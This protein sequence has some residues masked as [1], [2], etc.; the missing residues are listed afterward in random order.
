MALLLG[1]A[2]G[3]RTSPVTA[4]EEATL[5]AEAERFASNADQL[6]RIGIRY[7]EGG[8]YTRAADVLTAALGVQPSFAAAVYLGLAQEGMQRYEEAETA[9]RAARTFRVSAG[10]REELDR[11]LAAL[12]LVRLTAEARAAIARE[13]ELS[14]LPALPRSVAVL[15]WRFV[16]ENRRLA[17]LGAGV[18][19]LVMTDLGRISSLTLVE[20][21]RV[22]AL[23]DE[24]SLATSGLVDSA[25][26]V[27]SGRLLRAEWVVA[28]LVRQTTNGVRLEAKIYR[29]SDAA[30]QAGGSQQDRVERLFDMQKA[31]TLA[32]VEQLGVPVT[33][34][35]RRAVSE[36]PTADLQAFLAFSE[37]VAAQG[38]GDYRAAG[39]LF[40]LAAGRD[41]AFGMARSLGVL[42]QMLI[43]AE[44]SNRATLARLASPSAGN[45]AELRAAALVGAVQAVAPTTGGELD[46]RTRA[47]GWQSHLPETLGQDNPTK[48]AIIGEIV[49][50]IPRP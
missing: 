16:G 38:R 20:R 27:R 14:R 31:L 4:A 49:I 3:M 35:E 7:Y 8:R 40:A 28:G 42:N 34:A 25:T 37:G 9:Y 43:A 19:H 33:P 11:R 41:P 22:D 30:E 13:A 26:A 6:T 44:A 2:G 21:E 12:S 32:L 46:L 39:G 5:E 36:R 50:V 1:C 45:S 10:Q 23:V 48:I 17:P 24:I 47:P 29:T 18:P 15:P